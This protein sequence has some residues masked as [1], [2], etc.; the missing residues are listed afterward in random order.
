MKPEAGALVAAA[1]NLLGEAVFPQ[2]LATLRRMKTDAELTDALT[3]AIRTCVEVFGSVTGPEGT[4][5]RKAK[6]I[7]EEILS[8]PALLR[9]QDPDLLGRRLRVA[10]QCLGFELPEAEAVTNE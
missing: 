9:F 10:I 2:R 1:V 8:T 5:V 3:E 6:A 7:F 4:D